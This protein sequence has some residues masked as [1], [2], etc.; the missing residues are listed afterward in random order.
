MLASEQFRQVRYLGFSFYIVIY[1]HSV[2]EEQDI[3]DCARNELEQSQSAML[4][5]EQQDLL[6]FFCFC[7]CSSDRAS[8]NF[9]FMSSWITS[10]LNTM[11]FSSSEQVLDLTSTFNLESTWVWSRI[12]ISALLLLLFKQ[13]RELNQQPYKALGSLPMYTVSIRERPQGL[14]DLDLH[15]DLN[16]GPVTDHNL[17]ALYL[18]RRLRCSSSQFFLIRFRSLL[19]DKIYLSQRKHKHPQISFFKS[20]I[21]RLKK[22]VWKKWIVAREI[23]GW[24]SLK[25]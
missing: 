15:P 21:K 23:I 20:K 16:F 24:R 10:F 3:I 11:D 8:P 17:W 18:V 4:L 1:K 25:W 2:M 6:K 5:S 9:N 13:G 22:V 14:F 12:Y 7:H 19:L